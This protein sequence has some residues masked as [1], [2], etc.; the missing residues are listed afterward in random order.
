MSR[1]KKTHFGNSFYFCSGL[2]IKKSGWK[3][4]GTTKL[5]VGSPSTPRYV[6]NWLRITGSFGGKNTKL[7]SQTS[8]S[9]TKASFK[10]V[11]VCLQWGIVSKN[12][13]IWPTNNKVMTERK[14]WSWCRLFCCWCQEW[15]KKT[16]KK[17]K[18]KKTIYGNTLHFYT[19]YKALQ[20]LWIIIHN[21][22]S[23]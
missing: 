14:C 6:A 5:T 1:M 16:T 11:W 21:G 20:N 18:N 22:C 2:Y 4:W 17:K 10:Y 15:K 23:D 7:G 3:L 9:C 12:G 13:T 8:A 19:P